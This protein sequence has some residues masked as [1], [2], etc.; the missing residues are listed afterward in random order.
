MSLH[1]IY[2]I[3][4]RHLYTFR[5]NLDRLT[6]VF[7]WPLVDLLLWGLT[8]IF[9]E[10]HAGDIPSLTLMLI[11]GTIFWLIVWRGTAEITLGMLS[12]VV[13]KNLINLFVT[14]LKFWE[15]ISAFVILSVIKALTSFAF[16]VGIAFLLYKLHLLIYG[17]YLVPFLVILLIN[18]WC[19]GLFI[20]GFVLRYGMKAQSLAYTAAYVIAPFVAIFYPASIL[21]HWAQAISSAIPASYVFESMRVFI[22]SGTLDPQKL[23]L[24]GLL[25]VL[26]LPLSLLFLHRSF[27]K[28]LKRGLVGLH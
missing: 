25:S 19:I 23:Y 4:L 13:D 10:K 26:Y 2:A 28:A 21:P 8:G 7:Y 1:R 12:E 16:G 17:W 15:W 20:A 27:Q 3:I 5:K 24:A 14:P 11:S 18:G 6:D 22:A 9:I